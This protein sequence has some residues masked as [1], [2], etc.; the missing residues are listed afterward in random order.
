MIYVK[1]H[2]SRESKVVAMCDE[3]MIGKRFEEKGLCL[4]VNERFYK[5]RLV[6]SDKARNY[7]HN[8]DSA[9][10]VGKEAVD[11]ALDLGI[12]SRKSI[13]I[14]KNVPHAIVI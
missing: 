12:V 7:L 1:V 2:R 11:I 5:G 3:G 9:N 10:I 14:I 13:I 8:A 6:D 4:D